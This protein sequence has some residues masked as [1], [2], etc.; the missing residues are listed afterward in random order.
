MPEKL[1]KSYHF[2]SKMG[3][4]EGTSLQSECKWV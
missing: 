3:L 4:E 1:I 2:D